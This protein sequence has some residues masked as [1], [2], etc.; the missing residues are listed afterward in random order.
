MG[1]F[2]D[3]ITKIKSSTSV[4]DLIA[5][6]RRPG[7]ND[8]TLWSDSGVGIRIKDDGLL[9]LS[10]GP[11]CFLKL[12]RNTGQITLK[13]NSILIEA[14]K[15]INLTND[16]SGFKIDYQSLNPDWKSSGIF[17]PLVDLT[18]QPLVSNA[19]KLETDIITGVPQEGQVVIKL[20]DL[21][22]PKKLLEDPEISTLHSEGIA[23]IINI[24]KP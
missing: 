11:D 16:P 4:S 22:T 7:K 12:D 3:L 14:D 21:V 19:L 18:K 15:I 20:K 13:A 8:V 6:Q 10:A 24:D 1:F 17:E 5:K 9:E 23:N 2:Q